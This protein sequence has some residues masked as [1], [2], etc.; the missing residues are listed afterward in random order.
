MPNVDLAV[1]NS[2]IGDSSLGGY[3][4]PTM[5]SAATIAP[6]APVTKLTGVGPVSA[7]T[8][9]WPGFIGH[10]TFLLAGAVA[11]ATGGAAGSALTSPI[12]GVA[13]EAVTLFYDGASWWPMIAD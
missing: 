12:T 8:P 9:P 2:R 6:T 7:I 4:M 1:W 5:A 13:N 10:I 3:I 11:F